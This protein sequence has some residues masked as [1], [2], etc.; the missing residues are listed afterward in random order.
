MDRFFVKLFKTIK[1][2]NIEM[3]RECQNFFG[4][5]LTTPYTQYHYLSWL[6]NVDRSFWPDTN[7]SNMEHD[8]NCFNFNF[9]LV[10][11]IMIVYPC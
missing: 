9:W 6:Y 4:F 5:E 2:A 3:V 7:S 10:D 1:G 8:H 11:A